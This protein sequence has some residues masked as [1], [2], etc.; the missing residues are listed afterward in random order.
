MY[1]ALQRPATL[2]VVLPQMSVS[3][4]C[5]WYGF[6]PFSLFKKS[7]NKTATEHVTSWHPASLTILSN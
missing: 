4:D 5:G 1:L 3:A 2:E 6:R 7:E